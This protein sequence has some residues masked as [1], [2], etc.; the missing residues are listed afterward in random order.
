M[1]EKLFFDMDGVFADFIDGVE[2]L[3][4]REEGSL[5]RSQT[6]DL[7]EALG[8]SYGLFSHS[9]RHASSTEKF[10]LNLR[11]LPWAMELAAEFFPRGLQHNSYI[12]TSP[13]PA[14]YPCYAQKVEWCMLH[15]GIGSDRV[16]PFPHK[17]LLSA[18]GRTLIDDHPRHV[19]EWR[20]AGGTA[21][22]VP[23]QHNGDWLPAFDLAPSLVL[24]RIR[25]ELAHQLND[26]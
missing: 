23:C 6:Y 20:K 19:T 26:F 24:G 16:I 4:A 3:H 17:H 1:N 15:L 7:H 14:D 10:W 25:S 12:L 11:P 21:V 9:L 8:V 13:W 18:P 22:Q 2:R 5:K